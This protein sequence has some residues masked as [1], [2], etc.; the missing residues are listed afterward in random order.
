MIF[1]SHVDRK[2]DDQYIHLRNWWYFWVFHSSESSSE[3]CVQSGGTPQWVERAYLCGWVS[4]VYFKASDLTCSYNRSS[5]KV[6]TFTCES[7]NAFTSLLSLIL[8]QSA[9]FLTRGGFT[10]RP[11]KLQC[12]SFSLARALPKSST[13]FFFQIIWSYFY[14]VLPN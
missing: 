7:W 4:L 6:Y 1:F 12:S 13:F 11:M 2:N 5:W 14:S 8:C 10:M 3:L 9:A